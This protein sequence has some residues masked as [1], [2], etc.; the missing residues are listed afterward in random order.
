MGDQ[1]P[2]CTPESTMLCSWIHG[3][4]V[5]NTGR[6]W[7]ALGLEVQVLWV[8]MRICPLT[9]AK[10]LIPSFKE[11]RGSSICMWPG[12]EK[13]RWAAKQCHH[14]DVGLWAILCPTVPI[15]IP[16]LRCLASPSQRMC[17]S[18]LLS[19]AH[20]FCVRPNIDC[21]GMA[22]GSEHIS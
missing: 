8:L 3:L 4:P 18:T 6:K 15:F 22:L 17:L 10:L 1:L 7:A 12:K 19:P 5:Y 20:I 11:W 14:C 9:L 13:H 21:S 2:R 16:L